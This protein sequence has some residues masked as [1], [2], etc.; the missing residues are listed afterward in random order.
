MHFNDLAF[1]R[2]QVVLSIFVKNIF[3]VRM[4][5]FFDAFGSISMF[6]SRF[7]ESMLLMMCVLNAYF[8]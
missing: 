1:K 4:D 3:D 6:A 8:A 7:I 5:G 2:R